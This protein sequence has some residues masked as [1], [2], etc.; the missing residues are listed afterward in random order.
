MIFF[1][2]SH[3]LMSPKKASVAVV[4]LGK[5]FMA[6]LALRDARIELKNPYAERRGLGRP[7][8]GP[9]CLAVRDD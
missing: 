6:F 8:R 4:T 9:V 5:L 3:W 1:N 2:E 7:H